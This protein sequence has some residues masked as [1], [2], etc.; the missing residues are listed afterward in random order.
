MTSFYN[1]KE[2]SELGLK[3]YGANVLISKKCSIYSPQKISIGGNVR[4]DDFC[5]LSGE[6][7]L[8]S[9]IHI[10][11]YCALFGA[12]S[13][14]MED[15]TG[16]S[17]RCTVFSATD[18][19]SGDYLISPMAEKSTTNVMGGKVLIKKYSQVGANCI[20]FPCITLGEGVAVGAMSL[21]NKNLEE[22]GI[23]AGIPAKK[24][25]DRKKGLLN[26]VQI[27]EK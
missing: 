5:I 25:K 15:Y 2:L 3:K 20:L 26:F 8:G 19:F 23:Y 21:I 12:F 14:E 9:Y 18:N 1:E 10:A 24:I 27:D 11:A 4:I 16:L 22:W 7:T 17:P 13:I 6:I